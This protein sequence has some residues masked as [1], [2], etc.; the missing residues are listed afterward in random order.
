[1]PMTPMEDH[2]TQ[3]ISRM[4]LEM[5]AMRQDAREKELR[6]EAMMQ[7]MIQQQEETSRMMAMSQQMGTPCRTSTASES[8]PPTPEV[9]LKKLP[10]KVL[11]ECQEQ[12]ERLQVKKEGPRQGRWFYKCMQR[13]CNFFLWEPEMSTPT[14]KQRPS[15]PSVAASSSWNRVLTAGHTPVIVDLVSDQEL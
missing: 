10:E 6:Q 2:R 12:A 8:M 1:M 7:A 3:E 15:A 9:H 4:E 5:R 14:S 13:R 11:C